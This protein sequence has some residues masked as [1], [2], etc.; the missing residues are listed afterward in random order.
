MADI[1]DF[2]T[3]ASAPAP[4]P[5]DNDDGPCITG[6]AFC[7]ACRHEWV[8]VAPVGLNDHLECPSCH[9]MW[10]AFKS[11]VCPE[12]AW[13]CICGENLFWLTPNGA[14]CRRC[15]LTPRSWAE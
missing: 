6:K 10:G 9:R 1:V 12:A 7:G 13:T 5:A 4:E 11:A 14:M 2:P 8:A 3:K 15:G